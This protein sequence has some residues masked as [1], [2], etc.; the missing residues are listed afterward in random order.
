ML[1]QVL[2]FLRLSSFS[3]IAMFLKPLHQFLTLNNKKSAPSNDFVDLLPQR[4]I[5]F[6]HNTK[7]LFFLCRFV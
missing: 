1:V 5:V 6:I 3:S 7:R 4:I 2:P